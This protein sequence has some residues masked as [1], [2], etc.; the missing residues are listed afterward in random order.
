[1]IDFGVL[2]AVAQVV[3]F[4]RIGLEV[5]EDRPE[6]A[7]AVDQLV[8]PV[9]DHE[10]DRLARADLSP[11]PRAEL[12]LAAARLSIGLGGFGLANYVATRH[13]AYTGSFLTT[14][15]II[16]RASPFLATA[17]LRGGQFGRK[18]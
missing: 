12:A 8:P 17:A 6:P 14:W 13:A 11:G 5:E 4:V 18:V 9:G 3:Q 7:F 1:M 15:P 2:L 10:D 16:T